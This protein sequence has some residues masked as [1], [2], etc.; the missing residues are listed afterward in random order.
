[1]E[2]YERGKLFNG[3]SINPMDY[4]KIQ[5]TPASFVDLAGGDYNYLQG[6][7]NRHKAAFRYN[8]ITYKWDGK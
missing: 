2:A 5:R 6:V 7:A 4:P 3:P 8:G 1:M